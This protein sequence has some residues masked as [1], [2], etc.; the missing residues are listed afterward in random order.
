[1]SAI[2]YHHYYI[3]RQLVCFPNSCFWPGEPHQLTCWHRGR[4]NPAASGG[5]GEKELSHLGKIPALVGVKLIYLF[6]WLSRATPMAYGSSQA[7][8]RI[9]AA[10]TGLRHS[11]SPSG[12]E[13]LLRP[14]P[15]LMAMLD[16]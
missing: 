8:D 3:M 11:H 5:H 9:R 7:R 10:A 12:S 14:M 13:P 6:T 15:Q 2:N 4:V 1:M 16:P